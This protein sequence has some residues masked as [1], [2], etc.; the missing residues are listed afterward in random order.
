MNEIFNSYRQSLL[1]LKEVLLLERTIIHR[2]AAIQRF[3]FTVELA[4]KCLQ[5]FLK[6]KGILCRSPKDCLREAFKYGLLQDDPR[7]IQVIEERNLTVH[8]YNE[9]VAQEIYDRLPH[10]VPLFED[11]QEKLFTTGVG[12]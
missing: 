7:W 1:R 6:R 5:T 12:G 4:W 2:D 11:L 10:Y 3:E 8:T 9:G